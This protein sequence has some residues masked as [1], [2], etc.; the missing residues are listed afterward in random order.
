MADIAHL[1][2]I[3]SH[4]AQTIPKVEI[5]FGC[6][7]APIGRWEA[8]CIESAQCRLRRIHD[9]CTSSIM[10]D[11][12]L[13]RNGCIQCFFIINVVEIIAVEIIEG[14]AK[15]AK[16]NLDNI[17]LAFSG[18]ARVWV[19]SGSGSCSN[20]SR[21]CIFQGSRRTKCR[22][23]HSKPRQLCSVA[24]ALKATGDSSSLRDPATAMLG[25]SDSEG[26]WRSKVTTLLVCSVAEPGGLR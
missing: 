21:T 12:A 9:K 23:C 13:A 7:I 18:L 16:G 15:C 4:P 6:D 17:C 1:H 10:Q 25:S 14:Q 24:V 11:T 5:F 20:V 2:C 3:P 19:R 26:H 8:P 22:G